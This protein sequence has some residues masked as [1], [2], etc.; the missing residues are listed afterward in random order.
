MTEPDLTADVPAG[1]PVDLATGFGAG[2]TA[3]ATVYLIH[4]HYEEVED[5]DGS[6]VEI[7]KAYA[8]DKVALEIADG[9]RGNVLVAAGDVISE[10]AAAT[11]AA[12]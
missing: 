5:L 2:D 10:A 6:M 7:E 12:R 4:G 11:I 8:T 1:G 3:P 9:E